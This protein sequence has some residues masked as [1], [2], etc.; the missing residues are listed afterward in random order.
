MPKQTNPVRDGYV[1]HLPQTERRAWVRSPKDEEAWCQPTGRAEVDT[2]WL[3]RVRDISTAGVGL[4]MTR[5]FE[6][7]TTLVVELRN[8]T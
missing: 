1:K 5:R 6:P 7:G 3:G 2:A 4:S 8:G